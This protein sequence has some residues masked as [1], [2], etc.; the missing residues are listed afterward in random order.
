MRDDSD[1][2]AVTVF[3]FILFV[4]LFGNAVADLISASF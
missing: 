4:I 1:P 3:L 2:K